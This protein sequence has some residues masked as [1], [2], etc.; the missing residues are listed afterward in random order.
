M[1]LYPIYKKNKNDSIIITIPDLDIQETIT[2]KM[3]DTEVACMAKK[4]I[5]EKL[6][7]KTDEVSE[8]GSVSYAK[9]E[10]EEKYYVE[11]DF[12]TITKERLRW[13]SCENVFEFLN[14]DTE[15]MVTLTKRKIINRV[16]KYAELNP[17][18]V[19]IIS[20][21][22]NG[23]I[24]AKIPVN[25]LRIVRPSPGRVFSQEEIDANKKN[26]INLKAD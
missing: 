1:M 5:T 12:M 23:S 26:L 13:D 11:C 2:K 21:N 3:T 6:M 19:Q 15:A 24:Y 18:E 16:L 20:K 22:A 4:L 14:S 25:Y 8:P 7:N 17:N 9:E 10:N